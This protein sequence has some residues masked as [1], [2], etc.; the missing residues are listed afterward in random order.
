[1]PISTAIRVRTAPG[2]TG[3]SHYEVVDKLKSATTA[4]DRRVEWDFL[5]LN[6]GRAG[7]DFYSAAHANLGSTDGYMHFSANLNAVREVSEVMASAVCVLTGTS[8]RTRH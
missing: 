4:L 3:L 5:P 1:M 7:A 2:S 8:I 6:T